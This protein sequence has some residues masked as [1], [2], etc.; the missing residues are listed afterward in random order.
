MSTSLT[1]ILRRRRK[2]I[3]SDGDSGTGFDY[4]V[5]RTSMDER[6]PSGESVYDLINRQAQVLTPQNQQAITRPRTVTDA[7]TYNVPESEAT[8]Q[9]AVSFDPSTGRPNEDFYR[10][11]GD[12]AGLYNA[13]SNWNPH[14]GKR[15]FKNSLK[16]AL[17]MA[18]QAVQSNPDDPVTAAIAGFATGLGGA[19]AVPNF[20]NRLRRQQKLGQYG[21]ELHNQLELQKQQ[22]AID[23][24][25]M[26]EVELDNGQKV[27]V[28]KKS[29]ATLASRQQE[30][31]L[32]GDTLEAR[33]KRWDALGEHEGA[34]DAQALYN[35]GAADDS[36]ELRAEIA[37]RLQLP[38]GTVLPPR[39]LGNQIK[40]DD[41]GN[42]VIISPRSGAV[43]ATGQQSYEPTR[44]R[45]T[46]ERQ[47]RALNAAMERAKYN[48]EQTNKRAGMNKTGP[49]KLG[50]GIKR[51]I[52][53][54]YGEYD[55]FHTRLGALDDQIKQANALPANW[56]SDDGKDTKNA[57]LTRLGRRRAEAVAG[58]RK[59]MAEL[60]QLDPENE[61][62]AG[63][64]GYPYRKPRQ[65]AASDLD[66]PIYP[67]KTGKYAGKRI[68]QAN[69]AEYGRRHG[70][71]AEQARDYLA[72]E[73]AIIY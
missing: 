27:L 23:Q 58:I 21:G 6:T 8:R 63:E 3:Y 73:G 39:G 18:G 19:T 14:G 42:Y 33:K 65:Q 61:W 15:G 32:R 31:G 9:R 62:G 5:P 60:N 68:S 50:E 7:P 41:A 49:V 16:G 56:T 70:M 44:Q 40:L 48:Q 72:K 30:I 37:R 66:H 53:K 34:R 24:S 51:D 46:D 52:A 22:A 25:Q 29:A 67:N 2:K 4:G 20:T 17:M 69:V 11:R 38:A 1:D 64:G 55:E 54:G 47:Q 43:T 28:P 26:V 12:T 45:Y 35:S 13:Y 36:A 57:L 59:R 71:A 10:E